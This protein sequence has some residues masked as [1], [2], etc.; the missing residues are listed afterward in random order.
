M[1]VEKVHIIRHGQTG[2]NTE[3][4]LQGALPVPLNDCGRQQSRLLAQ[5][6]R[7]LSI[8]AI[9]TSPRTRAKETAQII[10]GHLDTTVYEDERLAEIAFGD[11]E[12]HTFAEVAKLY[13]VAYEKWESG[14]RRYRV[15]SGESRLDVQ[16]RMQAAWDEITSANDGSKTVAIV[17]H[18]SAMMIFLASMFAFLPAKPV[19]NTSITTLARYQDIWRIQSFAETPHL[20]EPTGSSL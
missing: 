10:G 3:R 11:F 8:D 13:P 6:L 5:Y 17:G 1:S 15:P 19:L 18:S 20:D 7:S 12:G 4:R 9:Y 14:Y 16:L 2:F